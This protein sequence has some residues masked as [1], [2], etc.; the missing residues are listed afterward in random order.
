MT[1]QMLTTGQVATEYGFYESTLRYYRFQG[2]G[3][4]SFKLGGRRVVYRRS[5]VEAWIAQQ[6]LTTTVGGVA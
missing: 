6:E 2:I 4:A 1:D 3:P 5:A